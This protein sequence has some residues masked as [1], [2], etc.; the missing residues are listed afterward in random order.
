MGTPGDNKQ[1]DD[2]LLGTDESTVGRTHKA[3]DTGGGSLVDTI[4]TSPVIASE[5]N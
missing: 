4:E 3:I 1:A 5:I 2:S